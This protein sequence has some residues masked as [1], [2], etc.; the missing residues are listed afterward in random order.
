MSAQIDLHCAG[1]MDLLHQG[2]YPR[3]DGNT[4][5]NLVYTFLE[6]GRGP[7]P[8]A[9]LGDAIRLT[10]EDG[11]HLSKEIVYRE[12]HN[13]V[14]EYAEKYS[15]SEIVAVGV[16]AYCFKLKDMKKIRLPS[17]EEANNLLIELAHML[18]QVNDI[19]PKSKW[20]IKEQKIER[21]KLENMCMGL[22]P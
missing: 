4:K 14:S 7:N 3:I 5:F 10:Y 21:T 17:I 22:C 2:V 1:F 6:D 18:D 12:I 8:C 16:K 9:T 13:V 19:K 15:E 20:D 11:R